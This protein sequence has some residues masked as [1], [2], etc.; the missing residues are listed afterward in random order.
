MINFCPI[1]SYRNEYNT[2]IYCMEHEC[3]WWDEEKKQCYIK[4][5]AL[6]AAGKANV[7]TGNGTAQAYYIPPSSYCVGNPID[8]PA[9]ESSATTV[10]CSTKTDPD[11]S[12]EA[13]V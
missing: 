1:M 10:Y 9:K 6:A 8:I 12:F 2:E 11:Y 7:E 4:T 5:M 13:G 3:A